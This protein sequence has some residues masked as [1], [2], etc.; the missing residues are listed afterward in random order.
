MLLFFRYG[1]TPLT[2]GCWSPTRPGVFFT[3]SM[4]GSLNVWDLCLKQTAPTLAIQVYHM[5]ERERESN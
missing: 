5:R 3:T 1:K 2:D 4:D